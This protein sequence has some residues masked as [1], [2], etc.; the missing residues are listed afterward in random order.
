[1][2]FSAGGGQNTP[3]PYSMSSARGGVT[4][5]NANNWGVLLIAQSDYEPVTKEFTWFGSVFSGANN[6]L[7]SSL[8]D[9]PPGINELAPDDLNNALWT[10]TVSAISPNDK[11]VYVVIA[12]TTGGVIAGEIPD[13]YMAF[14]VKMTKG[15]IRVF[16]APDS[17]VIDPI[18]L[19]PGMWNPPVVQM[20]NSANMIYTMT[21][22]DHVGGTGEASRSFVRWPGNGGALSPLLGT[23]SLMVSIPGTAYT[24]ITKSVTLKQGK[25]NKFVFQMTM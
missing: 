25:A 6:Q 9:V 12:H 14:F 22:F 18:T 1:M 16:V 11:G 20:D 5:G 2:V 3:F 23:H 4:D 24:P 17:F 8:V 19:T 13:H 21:P 7:I 15:D 10:S